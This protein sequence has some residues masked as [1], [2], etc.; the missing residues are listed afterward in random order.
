MPS[1]AVESVSRPAERAELQV[2]LQS[3]LFSRSPTLSHLLSYLCEK[4]FAG[5][6]EQIKE[7]SVALDVFD[8]H[9]SFDQDTD[10]IV[11]VQAN[12]LRKRLSEY[13]ASEGA[14]H[15]I[16]I[17]VPVGQYVPVFDRMAAREA[18]RRELNP[19]LIPAGMPDNTRRWV[20]RQAWVFGGVLVIS[21]RCLWLQFYLGK[22]QDLSRSFAL[23]IFSNLPQNRP[24]AFL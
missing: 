19:P 22:D 8:R 23:P 24:S 5:Q 14:A 21:W 7:Y 10:S 12:R 9:E 18:P 17:A 15:P 4:A 1:T 2:V 16:H 20:S 11:R 3:P 6:T 13:Y